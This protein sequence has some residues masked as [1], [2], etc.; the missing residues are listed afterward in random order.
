MMFRLAIDVGLTMMGLRWRWTHSDR[1]AM[2]VLVGGIG[3]YFLY[4]P[5]GGRA[6]PSSLASVAKS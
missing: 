5:V 4:V 2:Q 1:C 6:F 3:E